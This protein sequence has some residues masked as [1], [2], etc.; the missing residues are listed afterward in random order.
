LLARRQKRS[1]VIRVVFNQP[2]TIGGLK[3]N[4]IIMLVITSC[5]LIA[6]AWAEEAAMPTSMPMDCSNM[7]SAVQ[8]FAGQLTAANRTMFCSKFSDAQ[9]ASAMQMASNP[10]A[11]GNVV[12]PDDAVKSVSGANGS[13]PQSKTPVGCPVK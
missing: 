8:Q 3:M 4:K 9:R 12:S 7:S 11:S 6:Q 2:P 13:N 10:D 1:E 5:F